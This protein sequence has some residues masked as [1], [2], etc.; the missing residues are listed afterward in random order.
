MAAA[1][2]M[3]E[4]AE[5][6]FNSAKRQQTMLQQELGQVRERTAV[7]IDKQQVAVCEGAVVNTATS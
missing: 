2:R 7:N 3:L 5:L 1:E 4:A 6:E